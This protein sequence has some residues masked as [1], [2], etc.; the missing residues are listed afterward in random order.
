MRKTITIIGSGQL[1][2]MLCEESYNIREY[3]DKI[4]I[5]TDKED[6][7]C[8]YLDFKKFDYINIIKGEYYDKKLFEICSKSDFITYEFESFDIGIL[9]FD[10][11]KEKVYPSL[12][13]LK[14]IQDKYIQKTFVNE[15]IKEFTHTKSSLINTYDD[16]LN[17]I[18]ENDFPVFIKI[19]RGAFDGRGNY[20][21]KD[22]N[23][24]DI[25]KN[26][27][28]NKFFIENY[29][30]FDKEVSIGGCINLRNE[31]INYDIVENIHKESILISTIIPANINENLKLKINL[32][33]KNILKLFDTK[34]FICIE[35]FI[36][37]DE[38][39]FNE[40]CLRVHNSMHY[41][42][43]NKFP[44]QF[45]NHL[46]SIL[47]IDIKDYNYQ[48]NGKFFN[49]IYNLQSLDEITY[50]MKNDPLFYNN[51]IKMYNKK[52]LGIRKIGHVICEKKK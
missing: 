47:N 31:I 34:G 19:R 1:C 21:I 51:I 12:D 18:N 6:T 45:D 24:L 30:E 52:P 50:T 10:N 28:K 33:F 39:Y 16:I 36:K 13:I 26:I 25:F 42:L 35:L 41:T 3:I 14:I 46:R 22:I 38:I 43:C 2:L 32:I 49:I 48:F 7:P 23:D 5:Y 11:I 37:G 44:S 15:N 29:I 40:L 27:E 20:F 4:N 8:H 17:F 9:N